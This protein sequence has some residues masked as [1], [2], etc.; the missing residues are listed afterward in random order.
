MSLQRKDLT[1]SSIRRH[2]LTKLGSST[3][4]IRGRLRTFTGQSKGGI[5]N[6]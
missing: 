5:G 2:H 3:Y 6:A 1:D 4:G